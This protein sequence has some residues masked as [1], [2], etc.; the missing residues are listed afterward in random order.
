ML[1]SQCPYSPQTGLPLLLSLANKFPSGHFHVIDL[2][3]RLSSWACQ[4]PA[5]TNLWLDEKN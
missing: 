1:I 3:Y 4:K 2:P 5:N